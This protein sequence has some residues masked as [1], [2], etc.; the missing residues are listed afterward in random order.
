M[1]LFRLNWEESKGGFTM[2][3]TLLNKIIKSVTQ[4]TVFQCFKNIFFLSQEKLIFFTMLNLCMIIWSYQIQ[5]WI[6][7]IFTNLWCIGHSENIPY[8][9]EN[10]IFYPC[11]SETCVSP[12]C[13]SSGGPLIWCPIPASWALELSTKVREVSQGPKKDPILLIESSY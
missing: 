2:C 11:V 9:V 12:C 10:I 13:S 7:V 3:S 4:N 5:F 6:R 8:N 1:A